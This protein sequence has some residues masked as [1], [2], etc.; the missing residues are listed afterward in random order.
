M[1][2]CKALLSRAHLSARHLLIT[3]I[4]LRFRSRTKTG[5]QVASI[6]A[7]SWRGDS[8]SERLLPTFELAKLAPIFQASG[9]AALAWFR[10]R[11]R[12]AEFPLSLIRHYQGPY[13]SSAVQT[14][15]HEREVERVAQG[16]N[17]AGIRFILLK[18]WSLGRHYPMTSL[19][20]PG[21]IDL[22]IDP[23]Q[24][25]IADT[26]IT[27]FNV[28]QTLDLEHDQLRRFENRS[29]EEFYSS[30][31]TACLG[32]AEIKV[33]CREDEVRTACLHF[34]KH[35]G[36]RPI[37]LCDV[38]VLL[39]THNRSFDWKRCLG[40]DP[41]HERWIGATIALARDLLGFALPQGAPQSVMLP[42]PDWLKHTVLREWS[43]PRPRAAPAL[44]LLLPLLR[45]NPL[46]LTGSLRDRWRNGIQATIDCNATFSR[47]P[48]WPYQLRDAMNRA[49]HFWWAP[50]G[51][52]PAILNSTSFRPGGIG[53]G[54]PRKVSLDIRP[55]IA[56]QS[57]VDL[58]TKTG[59][60][61]SN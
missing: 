46:Q 26:L 53:I 47:F 57:D 30:C 33:L 6:L 9:T 25:R 31:E 17:L 15:A 18:G 3:V 52:R 7:R 29:F 22:W 44:A 23:E 1:L 19:R 39:D 54:Q 61:G 2:G 48:R 27:D 11:P 42:P 24:R 56:T 45:R 43:D 4:N 35:G 10:I 13:V 49:L 38:A 20:P 55:T 51:N 58:G 37:W 59:V 16:L 60:N 41:K 40:R 32:S 5:L 8:A 36:W 34:L 21:D 50:H 28:S 14:L 12:A